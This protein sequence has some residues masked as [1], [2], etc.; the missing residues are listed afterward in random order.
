MLFDSLIEV[1]HPGNYTCNLIPIVFSKIKAIQT[2][3]SRYKEDLYAVYDTNIILYRKQMYIVEDII[4]KK[5]YWTE[6]NIINTTDEYV[7]FN[8]VCNIDISNGEY[9]TLYASRP[10][11]IHEWNYFNYLIYKPSVYFG[12]IPSKYKIIPSDRKKWNEL[13]E[14]VNDNNILVPI[15][16]VVNMY[17]LKYYISTFL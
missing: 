1:Y 8:V 5:C 7:Y 4:N 3:K 11:I 6:L 13:C 14:I 10:F 9:T 17:D 16:K 12:K 2:E 15:S